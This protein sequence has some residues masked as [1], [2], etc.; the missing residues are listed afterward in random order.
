VEYSPD[1]VNFSPLT[2][3]PVDGDIESSQTFEFIHEDASALAFYRLKIQ[4]AD[5]VFT[6]TPFLQIGTNT[7]AE[8]PAAPAIS[9]NLTDITEGQ[10]AV[11]TASG[12]AHTVVWSTGQTGHSVTIKP[13]VTA[14]YT[15][16]CRQ[17]AG[18]E[19]PASASVKVNVFSSGSLPG[20]FE[21]YLGGIDCSSVR[22]WGWDRNKPNTAIYVEVLDGQKVVA[23]TIADFYR[24]EL[25]T[26]GKGNGM[27]AFVFSIPE[28]LKDNQVHSISAR[29]LGTAYI[30]KDS[31]KKITCKGTF[32]TPPVNQPPVGPSVSPQLATVNIPFTATLPAFSDPD[33]PSLTYTL[34]GLPNGLIFTAS[35]RTIQGTPTATAT[36]SLT[37]TA[38]DGALSTT[39]LVKLTI[40][41]GS[42]PPPPPV[43]VTG[44]FEGYLDK[45]E[46][47]TIR[48][49]VWDRNKPNEPLMVEFFTNGQS[50]GTARAD[51]FRQDLL[52][53]RK[54]NGN[55]VYSF[56]TPNEV[57]T[58][59]TFQISAKV[60]NSNFTLTWSPKTL[61][62]APNARLSSSAETVDSRDGF[63]VTPNPT[64]G[65]FDIHFY[66][67]A[68]TVSE[69]SVVDES[70][71][72]WYKKTVQGT[73]HQ[74]HKVILS[75]ARGL[76]V[77]GI[78]QGGQ[79]RSRKIILVR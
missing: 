33:S 35:T 25:K 38:S 68:A 9:T 22:G 71:R 46:C 34:A 6:Y 62:C 18:C 31:P 13:E 77:V 79:I 15:A 49:W 63:L 73:G 52:T 43:T 66:T 26:A 42:T 72:S 70:G 50:I 5:Q 59:Q 21:G 51:I 37:Y 17:E 54:G 55:H 12:C 20:N 41:D 75:G 4:T 61:N 47:G 56:T 69:L 67:E 58:G 23:T 29:V 76:F 30:L 8:A 19:S 7:C 27:H 2:T 53:A 14:V 78:R 36:Q 3:I 64:N 60:Q 10:T 16:R 39:V 74:Q 45:V 40:G 44:N 57:K 11:L 28:T 65:E 24:P 48:G 1:G 32:S